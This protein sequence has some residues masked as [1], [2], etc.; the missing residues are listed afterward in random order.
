[1]SL[2]Q[3]FRIENTAGR[4]PY[5]D[6]WGDNEHN[7]RMMR[8]AHDDVQHL[9]PFS[10]GEPWEFLGGMLFTNYTPAEHKMVKEEIFGFSNIEKLEIWFGN[11]IEPLLRHGHAIKTYEVPKHSMR[12]GNQQVSFRKDGKA[13]FNE[14]R[15][16]AA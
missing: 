1:M 5:V 14:K 4:G 10:K 8:R 6:Y 13:V 2:I 15:R 16:R 3:I 12:D 9:S 7:M 11:W